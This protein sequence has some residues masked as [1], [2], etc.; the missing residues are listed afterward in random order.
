MTRV[1]PSALLTALSNS[2]IEPFYAVELNF[3]TAALHLWTGYGDKTINSTTYTGTGNL[4][5]IDGLEEAADLSA[6]GTKLTLSGLDSGILTYALT[7]HYQGRLVKI[8]WGLKGVTDVVEVFS[9]YMDTMTINDEGETST[10]ELT[11]ESRLI[12]LERPANRRY[13]SESHKSVRVSKGLSGTD[14][15]FDWVAPLQD[16]SIAW[17]RETVNGDETT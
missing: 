9:G 7:E 12:T 15:F 14:T 10:I 3:D 6:R 11:V 4:L 1:V 13:T 5:N 2:E 16:K 17:G 8:Y